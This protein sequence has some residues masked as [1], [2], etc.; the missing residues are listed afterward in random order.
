MH[1]T[2]PLHKPLIFPFPLQ[3]FSYL[4]RYQYTKLTGQKSLFQLRMLSIPKIPE[5]CQQQK[6]QRDLSTNTRTPTLNTQEKAETGSPF[7]DLECKHFHLSSAR[8]GSYHWHHFCALPTLLE[9]NIRMQM[10][11]A[12]SSKVKPQSSPALDT[13]M[14]TVYQLP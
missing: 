4:L 11:S 13:P 6:H 14:Y 8:P 1:P 7:R 5:W 2:F 12:A 10:S 9:I 3:L